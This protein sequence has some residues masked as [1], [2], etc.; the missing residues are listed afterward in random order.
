[1][2]KLLDSSRIREIG[3]QPKVEEMAGL[4]TSYE[5]LLRL[6]DSPEAGGRL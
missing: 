3:W 6:L 4:K 2:A 5:D 1:M